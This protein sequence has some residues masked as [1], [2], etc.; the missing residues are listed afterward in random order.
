MVLIPQAYAKAHNKCKKTQSKR[1]WAFYGVKS[2]FQSCLL[3]LF[4]AAQSMTV[5]TAEV[6]MRML[7]KG[8]QID[9][10]HNLLLSCQ[11]FFIC[12][13]LV[14]FLFHQE[15]FASRKGKIS[16]YTREVSPRLRDQKAW[17]REDLTVTS[18]TC[19][20]PMVDFLDW[21]A[22]GCS[23]GPRHSSLP[24]LPWNVQSRRRPFTGR[25]RSFS[26]QEYGKLRATGLINDTACYVK[27]CQLQSYNLWGE[28]FKGVL[29]WETFW[30]ETSYRNFSSWT[31]WREPCGGNFWGNLLRVTF[32]GKVL[33]NLLRGN[34][35]EEPPLG[36]F[37]RETYC[38]K[39]IRIREWDMHWR[40]VVKGN[41]GHL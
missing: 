11:Y 41:G 1:S 30:E 21:M 25:G 19:W 26:N 16:T 36:K 4:L 12:S 9:S 18:A 8:R 33:G 39:H 22:K 20:Q 3:E 38:G 35:Q 32:W 31:F 17:G 29:L 13:I 23:L 37:L 6:N 24:L 10:T 34:F 7:I 40:V 2:I 5:S 27:K 14:G 28:T 15:C